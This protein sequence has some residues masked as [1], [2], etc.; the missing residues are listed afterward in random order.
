M[1]SV[2][3]TLTCFILSIISFLVLLSLFIT[4]L[5]AK[6]LNSRLNSSNQ[7]PLFSTYLF[8][9]S[10]CQLLF[11]LS[12]ILYYAFEYFEPNINNNIKCSILSILSQFSST[13][14]S[15]W[16]FTMIY[17]L[18]YK[19]HTT[20]INSKS[21][22][23]VS[24]VLLSQSISDRISR[25]S[26]DITQ[27][28]KSKNKQPQ[29]I[30]SNTM[31]KIHHIF[32]WTAS[33][34][35][36][37]IPFSVRNESIFCWIN[38]K[39]WTLP[40]IYLITIIM[41]L[42]FINL[43]NIH[44]STYPNQQ[45]LKTFSL[46]FCG[47]IL[48][49]IVPCFQFYYEISNG[50]N[51]QSL[52]NNLENIS[53]II[54]GSIGL[55][56]AIL[57]FT[58]Y[59]FKLMIKHSVNNKY[60]YNTSTVTSIKK[61]YRLSL[62]FSYYKQMKQ[63]V[64]SESELGYIGYGSNNKSISNNNSQYSEDEIYIINHKKQVRNLLYKYT[65]PPRDPDIESHVHD[66]TNWF[67]EYSISYMCGLML[68]G[69][70][71]TL[72]LEDLTLPPKIHQLPYLYDL[73]LNNY[74]PLK[75]DVN[76]INNNEFY[77]TFD[78]GRTI[79]SINKWCIIKVLITAICDCFM[80]IAYVFIFRELI[81]FLYSNTIDI[82]WGIF[83]A[84]LIAVTQEIS[85]VFTARGWT[86]SERYA[87]SSRNL[88]MALVFR[89]ALLIPNYILQDNNISVGEIVNIMSNDT[90]RIYFMIRNGIHI[91]GA[92][93]N[94]LICISF[95]IWIVGIESLVGLLIM[96]A[97]VPTNIFVG[98]M[99]AKMKRAALTFTDKRVKFLSE[100]LN[101]VKIIK[102]YAW[103]EPL[104]SVIHNI[105]KQELKGF[106]GVYKWR[107]LLLSV[108]SNSA[109]A[110]IVA[111]LAMK[112]VLGK[113]VNV[114]EVYLVIVFVSAIRRSLMR[115]GFINYAISGIVSINRMQ[116]YFD[117]KD[118]EEWIH[119]NIHKKHE[120]EESKY[121]IEDKILIEIENGDFQHKPNGIG[122][123]CSMNM[124][125]NVNLNIYKN[126]LIGIIGSVGSGKTTLMKSI[127]GETQFNKNKL[128]CNFKVS[129]Q[130]NTAWVGQSNF[131]MNGTIRD[132]IIMDLDFELNDYNKVIVASALIDD[133][134]LLIAGDAT[135]IGEKGINLSGGQRA[136]VCIARSFYKC[137][138]N[139]IDLLL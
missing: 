137:I 104:D 128:N 109:Y 38:D 17:C 3:V 37:F 130:I 60:N 113:P 21:Q 96:I 138:N 105:R 39:Y 73:F 1:V 46:Y 54:I 62:S 70:R 85:Y 87:I 103:E 125:K 90:E 7:Y 44:C 111:I 64:E 98:K 126:E 71:K 108:V 61:L 114:T 31:I 124:L 4:L 26:S 36:V 8:Y 67:T 135:E 75:R 5:I 27:K 92:I 58:N 121:D 131:I 116:K 48:L 117:N 100:M 40:F 93:I 18:H 50:N 95:M 55:L 2:A 119:E 16:I 30:I 81:N 88:F 107:A 132:N 127:L 120:E 56:Y 9:D 20:E 82:W 57:W 65:T 66:H 110:T 79:L 139:N 41:L 15:L 13:A 53:S 33:I 99:L 72:E 102:F 86:H 19:L 68:K 32:I 84:I 134:K 136:R 59:S 49:W 115:L 80:Q 129:K 34:L 118:H 12:L 11:T 45:Y 78:V 77:F 63:N 28:H 24:D 6:R 133:L 89:K 91:P 122:T 112:I 83:W 94:I 10:I 42:I 23:R 101:G 25:L 74:I 43:I 69:Y 51:N 76:N 14:S 52:R 29:I 97:L 47:Y 22:A 35:F 123:G 106:Q